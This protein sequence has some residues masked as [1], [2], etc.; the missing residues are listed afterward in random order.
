LSQQY[1]MVISNPRLLFAVAGFGDSSG[2]RGEAISLMPITPKDVPDC[3]EWASLSRLPRSQLRD[4]L[5]RLRITK[6]QIRSLSR[7]ER[8]SLLREK[9]RFV[10]TEEK[11]SWKIQIDKVTGQEL[12]KSH[13]RLF[14]ETFERQMDVLADER[15]A[16]MS[17]S[18]ASEVEDAPTP[19]GQAV[20]DTPTLRAAEANAA[21]EEDLLDALGASGSENEDEDETAEMSKLRA[22]LP[23]ASA[24]EA[25]PPP[26]KGPPAVPDSQQVPQQ[27]SR[28]VQ[29]LKI[30]SVEKNPRGQ[31]EER[32]LYVFGEEDIRRYREQQRRAAQVADHVAGMRSAR[33]EGVGSDARGPVSGVGAGGD[34][35]RSSCSGDGSKHSST[36]PLQSR[37]AASPKRPSS[38]A[39]DSQAGAPKRVLI[40]R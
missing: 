27:E 33:E 22:S 14:Q 12:K 13:D 2:G 19:A 28:K 25:A 11:W 26:S 3:L 23:S 35:G 1:A 34:G 7:W 30:I 10:R 8:M 31:L 32:V 38:E 17:D 24:A 40:M 18:D 16:A 15:N 37:L 36:V 29:M 21:A 39:V 4:S 5:E 9:S 6:K 20:I